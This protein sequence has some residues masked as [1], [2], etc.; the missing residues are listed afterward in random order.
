MYTYINIFIP[1]KYAANAITTATIVIHVN[2]L[3]FKY[4]Y[5]H[6]HVY[7]CK[8]ILSYVYTCPICC[9]CD[10]NSHI[11]ILIYIHIC[12]YIYVQI[13]IYVYLHKET[14]SHTYTY[15]HVYI[16]VQYA[17]NAITTATI[18]MYVY[19]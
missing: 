17:A 19:M 10:H 6:I 12:I 4:I 11:I 16:P 7:I 13:Y 2:F 5:R 18:V 9:E 1:V 8:R 3:T 15:I 14:H